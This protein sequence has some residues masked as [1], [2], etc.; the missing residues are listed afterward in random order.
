MSVNLD[1]QLL[2]MSKEYSFTSLKNKVLGIDG[3]DLIDSLL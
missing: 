2:K 3:E 1:Q